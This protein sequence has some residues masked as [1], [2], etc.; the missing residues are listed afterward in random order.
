MSTC[1]LE[2]L[3]AQACAGGFWCADPTL[4]TAIRM[5]LL[6]NIQNS[7]APAAP[8]DLTINTTAVNGDMA[9]WNT[10]LEW[11]QLSAP[12]SNE[13][14]RSE[15]GGAYHMIASVAGVVLTY[16]DPAAVMPIADIWSYKVRA[17]TSGVPS[18]F[19]NVIEAAMGIADSSSVIISYPLLAVSYFDIVLSNGN[20]TSISF[21]LLTCAPT[22][23]I[24]GACP[25]LVSLSL[26]LLRESGP[27]NVFDDFYVAGGTSLVALSLPSY[28]SCGGLFSTRGCTN[29]VSITLNAAVIFQDNGQSIDCFGCALNV[30]TVNTILRRCAVSGLTTCIIDLSGGTSAAPTGQGIIDAATLTLAGCT[31]TTN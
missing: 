29:M 5:Q 7:N 3:K 18:V 9:T 10:K 26:P 27:P 16:T 4:L 13:V 25:L 21:P 22:E 20:V 24:F 15:N 31:V 28:V 8:T 30:A 1:N 6:C 12:T 2:T 14:W 19:S 11:A 23:Q 17:V